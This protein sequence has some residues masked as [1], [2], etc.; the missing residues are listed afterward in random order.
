MQSTFSYSLTL[1]AIMLSRVIELADMKIYFAT[2]V[3]HIAADLQLPLGGWE[4]GFVDGNTNPMTKASL[5]NVELYT[6]AWNNIWEWGGGN[7]AYKYANAGYKV[8]S[9]CLILRSDSTI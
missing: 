5:S 9:R 7:Q 2:R 1:S 8:T 3:A 4:D 6:M